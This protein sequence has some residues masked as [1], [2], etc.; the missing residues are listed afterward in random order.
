MK[1][2]TYSTRSFLI[3][4]TTAA[5]T[6]C[7]LSNSKD[8]ALHVDLSAVRGN[9]GARLALLNSPSFLNGSNGLVPSAVSGFSCYGVNVTG[10]GIL[11][12]S[13]HPDPDSMAQFNKTLT[14][15]NTYCSYRGVVTPPLMLTS[16]PTDVALAVPPG[17]V[18]LVQIVG[19]N[20]PAV[21]SSG[22]LGNEDDGANT[23]SSGPR[24]F[25]LGRAVVNNMFSDTSVS[26]GL[27][28]PSGTT[29]ADSLD[30]AS[31]A[32]DCGGNCSSV[33]PAPTAAPAPLPTSAVSVS[34]SMVGQQIPTVPGKYLRRIVAYL[35]PAVYSGGNTDVRIE[36]RE[37]ASST[38]PGTATSVWGATL[39]LAATSTAAGTL[40]PNWYT[41][42]MKSTS[43]GYV[44]M[45]TGYYYWL[46]IS[47]DTANGSNI[48]VGDSS[49]NPYKA[50]DPV[51]IIQQ[52]TNNGSSWSTLPNYSLVT[53]VT[54]CD[55]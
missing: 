5:L 35:A 31:R 25:E 19:V 52:S 9:P 27:N 16:G 55:N 26:V 33:Q 12:S 44:Q 24:Y 37:T 11:D 4:A 32:L 48:A 53:D 14:Q 21:C 17:N 30:R 50:T 36:V 49:V 39:S 46:V 22:V 6:A 3:T 13:F 28:W 54:G 29:V 42:E 43:N 51:G 2:W 47:S 1:R 38:N 41:F 15:P 18:R 40:A 45:K 10:P 7:S 34:G 23:T 8:N 20:D